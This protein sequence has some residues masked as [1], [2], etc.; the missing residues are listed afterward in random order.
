MKQKLNISEKAY[1]DFTTRIRDTFAKLDQ[2]LGNAE[3]AIRV[4]DEYIAGVRDK[5]YCLPTM[6]RM[7][8]LILQP[9]VDKCLARSAAARARAAARAA[10]KAAEKAEAEAEAVEVEEAEEIAINE[11]EKFPSYIPTVPVTIR[12]D[13]FSTRA[14]RRA[15]ARADHPRMKIKKLG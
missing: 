13:R 3:Q 5:F 2:P 12:T 7:A 9:E 4:L 10:K 8:L 1:K 14:E 6:V 11:T 15:A